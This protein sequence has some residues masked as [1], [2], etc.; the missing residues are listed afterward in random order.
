LDAHLSQGPAT[1]GDKSDQDSGKSFF[2]ALPAVSLPKGG[3]AIRSVDEKF[4]VNPAT[5]TGSLS[6]PVFASPG[7]QGFGPRL[8]LSYDSGAGNGPFGLGWSLTVPNISRKTDKVSWPNILI[9][10]MRC[11]TPSVPD[12][13]VA[14]GRRWLLH[15]SQINLWHRED[16]RVAQFE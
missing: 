15:S 13:N 11:Y 16:Q 6:I 1:S 2:K 4:Q 12:G 5:G 9:C 7:R 14:C 3:G 8:A 10:F